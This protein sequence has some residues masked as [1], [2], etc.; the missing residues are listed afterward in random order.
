MADPIE[1]AK[2]NLEENDILGEEEDENHSENEDQVD[3]SNPANCAA[4]G[5]CYC[6]HCDDE[7][8]DQD[9]D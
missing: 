6:G 3:W 1:D 2:Q 7:D 4:E 8:Q 9:Q 5:C